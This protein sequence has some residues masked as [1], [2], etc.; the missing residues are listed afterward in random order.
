MFDIARFQIIGRVG[1][2]R[3]FD[4]VTRISVATN[5]SYKGGNGAWVDR[6]FWN[7]G[8]VFDRATRGF[9]KKRLEVGDVVRIEGTLQQSSFEHDGEKVYTTDLVVDELSRQPKMAQ[10]EGVDG[11]DTQ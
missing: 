9:I 1:A 7:E 11:K 8:V 5:A 4:K 6:I 10:E 2:I 3:P